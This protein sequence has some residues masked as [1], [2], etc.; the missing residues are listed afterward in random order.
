MDIEQVT[1]RVAQRMDM[2]INE[3]WSPGKYRRT[4]KARS[5]LCYWAVRELGIIMASLSRR[6]HIS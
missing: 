5:L 3:I 2:S 4:V 6:L 1:G